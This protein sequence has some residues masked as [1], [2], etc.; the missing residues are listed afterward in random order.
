MRCAR[1]STRARPAGG[2]AAQR[3]R[4]DR[5]AA[6][7][8]AASG[9]RGPVRRAFAGLHAGVGGRRGAHGGR[10]RRRPGC[11]ARPTTG[12]SRHPE[13]ERLHAAVDRIVAVKE[14]HTRFFDE[15]V[16]RRLTASPRAVAAGAARAPTH[17]LA[18][19][20]RRAHRG[21]ARRDSRASPSAT[22]EG[23]AR[24]A[25]TRARHRG[26]ARHGR[27][28]GG[29]R[30]AR[31]RGPSRGLITW[32]TAGRGTR[33]VRHRQ[34]HR[35]LRQRALGRPRPRGRSASIRCPTPRCG[36]CGTWPTSS[37]TRSAT[38]VTC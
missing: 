21:G 25:A 12:W 26:A 19:R 22:P 17:R 2:P 23:N 38:R 20:L 15:E 35:D 33:G 32:C 14:R 34:V 3:C 30:A 1:S 5:T 24:A 9:G 29:D 4:R 18:A 6:S 7:G 27:A 31:T 8:A 11:S 10:P 13:A 28:H 36:R 37:T 16:Q